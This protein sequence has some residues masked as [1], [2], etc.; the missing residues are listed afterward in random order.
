M[1][2]SGI[3]FQRLVDRAAFLTKRATGWGVWPD[4]VILGGAKCASSAFYT[5][6]VQH[7][8]IHEARR[9]EVHYYDTKFHQ[10]PKWYRAN[11]PSRAAR[12][13]KTSLRGLAFS[14]GEASPY[15]LFHPHAPRRM[16]QVAPQTKLIAIL[17][18]PA[19]RAF[20]H[21]KHML[22]DG[23][24]T[25]EFDAAVEQEAE[26]LAGEREKLMADETYAANRFRFFSYQARGIYVDQL[27]AWAEH[28]PREQILVLQ[29]EAYRRDP[30]GVTNR[31]LDFLGIPHWDGFVFE[32]HNVGG[33]KDSMS[34][35][36][37]EK[38]RAYFKPHN[39]RL[40]NWLGERW[41]WDD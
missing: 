23:R 21:Y 6:L 27:A 4:F 20:S 8:L 31:T 13:W 5:N 39:E 9:K 3:S 32:R 33:Y 10:G 22:R 15:Y 40:W 14:T 7:P 11:F 30:L 12:W 38:L 29:S 36:T 1:P 25:L 19:S 26:R 37:R 17:R 35:A 41:D 18:E 16:R 28:F 24:E 34:D 2:K